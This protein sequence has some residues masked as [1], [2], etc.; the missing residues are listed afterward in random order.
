MTP[1]SCPPETELLAASRSGALAE[2]LARHLETCPDCAALVAVDE[3]L[4]STAQALAGQADLPSPHTVLLRGRLAARRAEAERSLRPLEWWTRLV[5]VAA[6]VALLAGLRQVVLTLGEP[7]AASLGSPTPV[8][9][10]FGLGL[11][12]VAALPLLSTWRRSAV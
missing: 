4:R 3:A 7:T 8:Q 5:G 1:R 9:V 12:A 6:G 11:L 10:A 2:T